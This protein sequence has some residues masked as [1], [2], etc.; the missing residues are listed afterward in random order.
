MKKS[1]LLS[2]VL[3][4]TLSACSTNQAPLTNNLSMSKSR[5]II[6]EV[7]LKT[8]G[9]NDSSSQTLGKTIVI[10]END[11]DFEKVNFSNKI[12]YLESK[13]IIKKLNTNI[14]TLK[15][16]SVD[17]GFNF[18]FSKEQNNINVSYKSNLLL[19]VNNKKDG[20]QTVTT[21]PSDGNFVMNKSN[22]IVNIL[23][24]KNI[25]SEVFPLSYSNKY[26][27]S[28]KYLPLSIYNVNYKI[29][30]NNYD[31]QSFNDDYKTF[32]KFSQGTEPKNN[33]MIFLSSQED[34]KNILVNYHQINNYFVVDYKLSKGDTLILKNV[35]DGSEVKISKVFV[36]Y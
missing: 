2:S 7:S 10:L 31:I 5:P 35:E 28:V 29:S 16:G 36:L 12:A 20:T 9:N 11:N 19:N 27:L 34:R 21:I 3:F 32:I 30:K 14:E 26:E 17:V 25:K 6:A 1:L 24:S 13:E 18:I 33:W 15:T 4:A 22:G 8:I 23:P